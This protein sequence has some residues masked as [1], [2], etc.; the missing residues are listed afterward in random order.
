MV[1]QP[2]KGS[3]FISAGG[4]EVHPQIAGGDDINLRP[5]FFFEIGQKI[6]GAMEITGGKF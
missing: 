3:A 4:D 1:G 6:G 2:F 5:E